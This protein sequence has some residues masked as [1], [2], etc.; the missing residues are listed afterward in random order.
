[1]NQLFSIGIVLHA[2]DRLSSPLRGV[3][4]TV[5][6]L[7]RTGSQSISTFSRS[8]DVLMKT[9]ERAKKP[10]EQLRSQ[11][12]QIKNIGQSM[13]LKGAANVMIGLSPTVSAANFEK[14]L[15]EVATLTDMSVQELKDKYGK[16]ILDLSQELGQAPDLIVKGMYQAISAGVDPKE[17]INFMKQAGKAAI[18]GASDI[19]TATDLATSIKNA[20]NLP[21]ENMG[22][23]YDVIFK[24]V[25]KGKTTF[26]EIAHS[27]QQVGAAAAS[28]GISFE[29]VQTAVAQMTLGGVK[30]E[31]AY[32][33]LKYVI[34][35]LVAPADKAKKIFERLGLEINAETVRQK[36]LLG[37]MGELQQAMAGL[38]EKEQAEM[39]ADIFGSQEAQ[40]FVKDFMT[41]TEKY[42]DMLKEIKDS[43]G[44]TEDAYKKME[45]TSAQQ[46]EK[47][48]QTLNSI[49]IALGES[50]LPALNMFMSAVKKIAMPVAEFAQKH[51]ILTGVI[52]G[53]FI[54]ISAIVV[55]LGMMGIVL[56]MAIKG[57]TNLN[58]LLSLVTAN[59]LRLVTAIKGL[60]ISAISGIR[61]ISTALLTTPVGWIILGITALVAAGYLL[62]R[63]WDKVSKAL[64]SAW[65]WLKENWKKVLQVFLYINPITA[66]I[67][68]LK[69]LIQ[70]VSGI[71]LFQAGKTIIESLWKGIQSVAM[72]PVEA[73]K[74]IAQKIRNLLPFSPAKEGPLREIHRIR[75]IETIAEAIKPT[76]LLTA[77]TKALEPV[78][79]FTQPL[80]QPVK[81]LLEPV[82]TSV[83]PLIQPVKQV[84]EPVKSFAQPQRGTKPAS[85]ITV[86]YNPTINLS[87]A[88][89]QA[90]EDFLSILRQHQH[91][92][93]KLIQDAQSK[94]MRVAY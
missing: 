4:R 90:K 75:L 74:G 91:E 87:G 65:N 83:N 33:S 71:D 66:P 59:K 62:W 45:G 39:I 69:K 89:V 28:A 7:G 35:A 3:Q 85:T 78:K 61:A 43:T 21:M 54:A 80:I 16:Q 6:E 50:I 5:Q 77:M 60:T 29:H 25:Q 20:F 1:M 93:L 15:A 92:L 23:V 67:M 17:A 41:N 9:V 49:K 26:P 42:K 10:F 11:A 68:A 40:M 38:S 56:G 51:K 81:Q 47:L 37:I 63:N 84:L 31:R 14:G 44:A 57:Y 36:D 64:G 70:Y 48:K 13:A 34:D 55:S 19:F 86:N 88:N 18:A 2:I 72:K 73:V 58:I 82:K 22:K 76:P 27:F 79:S 24:T 53:G 52:L 8:F 30:T 32:T 46:F 94:A 12:E